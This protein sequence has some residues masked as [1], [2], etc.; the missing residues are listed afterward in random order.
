LLV[1]GVTGRASAKVTVNAAPL[2]SVIKIGEIDEL[3]ESVKR[4]YIFAYAF[5]P[6]LV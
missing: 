1:F 2:D 3:P 5:A 6:G 4:K